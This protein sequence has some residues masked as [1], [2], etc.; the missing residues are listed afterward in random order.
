MEF[1]DVEPTEEQMILVRQY[2]DSLNTHRIKKQAPLGEKF[3]RQTAPTWLRFIEAFG[4]GDPIKAAQKHAS[5]MEGV[6]RVMSL[7]T[8]DKSEEIH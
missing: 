4:N 8:S 3:I 7:S 1:D 6:N 2:L 5:V